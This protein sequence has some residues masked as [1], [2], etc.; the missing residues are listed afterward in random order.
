MSYTPSQYPQDPGFG[1]QRPYGP[2]L[3]MDAPGTVGEPPMGEAWYGADF[4]QA[5]SRFV[6]KAAHFQ[7]Y[8][9]RGEY[10]WVVLGLF[11]IDAVLSVVADSLGDTVVAALVSG[12]TGVWNLVVLIPLLAL[13]WR[14]LHDAGYAGT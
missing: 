10:W 14:R 13:T 2:G 9:S 12:L 5:V 1:Q 3:S 6:Q 11:V 7:G 4:K 8:A